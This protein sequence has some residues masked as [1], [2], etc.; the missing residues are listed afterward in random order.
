MRLSAILL[1]LCAAGTCELPMVV[2][3]AVVRRFL[4]N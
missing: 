1:V 4:N 2:L 3:N